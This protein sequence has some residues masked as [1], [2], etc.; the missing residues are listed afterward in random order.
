MKPAA[1]PVSRLDG[2]PRDRTLADRVDERIA[3]EPERPRRTRVERAKR[4]LDITMK[5][6]RRPP[7]VRG[8]VVFPR[9]WAVEQGVS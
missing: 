3:V 5:T 1:V 2:L 7:D 9:R 6:V 8:F 4:Y